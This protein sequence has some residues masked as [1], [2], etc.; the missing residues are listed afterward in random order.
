MNILQLLAS[1]SYITVNKYLI[2]AL[3]LEES[4]IFGELASEYNYWFTKE[5][6]KDGYFYSTIENM[7]EKTTLSPHKQ[8]KALKNLEE[9]G[10]INVKVQGMPATRYIKINYDAVVK[11]FNNQLLKNLTTRC[12]KNEQ[13]DVKKFNGNNNIYKNNINNNINLF[14]YY[15][16]RINQS[17]SPME[18]EKLNKWLEIFTED[19][20]KYAIDICNMNKANNIKY[21]EGILNNWNN[22]HYKTLQEIKEAGL[23]FQK[24]KED[25]KEENTEELF[26]YNWLEEN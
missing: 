20:I 8:R 4:I 3:G 10:L 9:A 14:I 5:E 23:K 18:F 13:L 12:E 26:S 19:I 24:Q 22:N 1:D 7:Q 17:I 16:E 21:L 6:L 25:H 15:E 11:I 2:N